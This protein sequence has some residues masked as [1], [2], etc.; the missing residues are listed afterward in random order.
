M[1][2]PHRVLARYLDAW[3]AQDPDAIIALH[4]ENTRFQTHAGLPAVTGR[5][6]VRAA[7]ADL[8]ERM[9]GVDFYGHRVLLGNTHWVLDWTVT[10]D[11][12]GGEQRSLDCVDVVE[13][14]A[15]GL[16]DRK[17]VFVD[18]AQFRAAIPRTMEAVA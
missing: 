5:K 15:D 13:L 18:V 16:V 6:A 8:F 1:T 14:S 9:P 3:E 10:F 4:T 12:P 2:R 17:D 7:F 11:G